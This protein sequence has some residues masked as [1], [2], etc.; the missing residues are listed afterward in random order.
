MDTDYYPI[1]AALYLH[2]RHLR[3]AALTM[4]VA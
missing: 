2:C 3:A 1:L 4:Q